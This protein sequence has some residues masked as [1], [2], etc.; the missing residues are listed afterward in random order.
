MVAE[1]VDG[2]V[3]LG[4]ANH[5]SRNDP[6]TR[7]CI[8]IGALRATVA[9]RGRDIPVHPIR[10]RV[11]GFP[12]NR[13]KVEREPRTYAVYCIAIDGPLPVPEVLCHSASFVCRELL[14]ATTTHGF[15]GC[16]NV[17]PCRCPGRQNLSADLCPAVHNGLEVFW[18]TTSRARLLSW[19]LKTFREA[20]NK[21]VGVTTARAASNMLEPR[22]HIRKLEIR[23][24]KCPMRLRLR[25]RLG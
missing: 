23:R 5:H 17:R 19:R 25:R 1:Q 13:F 10:H 2:Q 12:L 3:T 18:R 22:L 8:D 11:K 15:Q 9:G 20:L 7:V 4:R 24:L 6:V 16:E 14:V 21:A